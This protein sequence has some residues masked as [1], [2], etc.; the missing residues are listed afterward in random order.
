MAAAIPTT[1]DEYVQLLT[2]VLMCMNNDDR[3]HIENTVV[4]SLKSPTTAYLLVQI[5]DA[6]DAIAPEMS[7]GVRQL[8]AVLLRKRVLAMWRELPADHQANLKGILLNRMGTEPVRL[9]RLAIAHVLCVLARVELRT[10]WP[11]LLQA[12]NAA[13]QS[14]SAEHREL[15]V[16]LVHS[17]AHTV[18]DEGMGDGGVNLQLA[19]DVVVRGLE[20]SVWAVRGMA[21]RAVGSLAPYL[22]GKHQVKQALVVALVP[23]VIQLVKECGAQTGSAHP[24]EMT[25]VALQ[26]LEVLEQIIEGTPSKFGPI[27]DIIQLLMFTVSAPDAHPRVREEASEVLATLVTSRP[28]AVVNKD[29]IAPIVSMCL[30]V[31]SEDDSYFFEAPNPEDEEDDETNVDGEWDPTEAARPPCMFAGRLLSALADALPSK[32]VLP[33]VMQQVASVVSNV[34]GATPRVRKATVVALAS[35]AEGCSSSLRRQV[36]SVIVLVKALMTDE[37]PFVR[38]AAAY[39]IARFAET[40]QPEILTAH[41]ELMPL[42]LTQLDDTDPQ[43]RARVTRT[44]EGVCDELGPELESYVTPLL[45]K[46]VAV[47]PHSND[48]TQRYICGTFASIGQSKSP[49]VAQ[50][51]ADIFNLLQPATAE[52]SPTLLRAKAIEAVGVIGASVGREAFAPVFDYFWAQALSG[53]SAKYAELREQCYG[54]AC[55]VAGLLGMDFSPYAAAVMPIAFQLLETQDGVVKNRN[56]LAQA[57]FKIGQDVSDSD[58]DDADDADPSDL[59]LYI[60]TAEI[61]ERVA[62]IYC[63]GV[64]AGELGPL[65]APYIDQ[66]VHCLEDCVMQDHPDVRVNAIHALASTIV[67]RYAASFGAGPVPPRVIGVMPTEDTLTEDTRDALDDYIRGEL[68]PILAGERSPPVVAAACDGIVELV[69]KMGAIAV[70]PYVDEIV[71]YTGV[72]LRREAPCQDEDED[73]DDEHYGQRYVADDD[74]DDVLIDSVSEIVDTLCIAYGEAFAPYFHS[75]VADVLPYTADDM[76]GADHVFA[77]GVIAG[78]LMA[79]GNATAQ[80]FEDGKAV[81]LRLIYLDKEDAESVARSNCC[82]LLRALVHNATQLMT[83]AACNEMLQAAWHIIATPDELPSTVDNAVSLVCSLVSRVP[84]LL[85]MAT[86]LPEMLPRLPMRQDR[87]ENENA[88]STLAFLI[89][90]HGDDVVAMAAPDGSQVYPVL[91]A[92]IARS[93]AASTVDVRLKAALQQ[94]VQ[95]SCAVSPARAQAWQ[96]ASSALPNRQQQAI[97]HQWGA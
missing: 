64:T 93:L 31:M 30:G 49:S 22:L 6:P 60:K 45:Q 38:G 23:R 7:A 80:Y 21:A 24:T 97:A 39:S 47:L 70:H 86:V 91:V 12:I 73:E 67:A 59:R 42:L 83:P 26:C 63:I 89:E 85:P 61:E 34:R 54:F 37:E 52:P 88:L 48:A 87:D 15:A 25:R 32:R 44:L 84:Q 65:F 57:D 94:A 53:L 90:A 51:A 28:K 41:A 2:G 10:G 1:A 36:H 16:M 66:A 35:V 79:L 13:G 71:K 56:P 92:A 68:L 17:L 5:I 72:L 95:R 3:R 9:V 43:V 74:H 33:H 76:P 75:L 58:S 69:N 8:A 78:C 46:L 11:E 82:Y 81:A 20:D 50:Y 55:N 29:L 96:A 19:G 62:A 27:D 18:T 40:L 4:R 14:E 77:V